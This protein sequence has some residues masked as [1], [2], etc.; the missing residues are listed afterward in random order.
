[1][2]QDAFKKLAAQLKSLR[3]QVDKLHADS[4]AELEALESRRG[5]SPAELE[6]QTRVLERLESVLECLEEAAHHC[7]D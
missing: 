5:V 4:E 2:D 3:N 7:Q 6:E 1:M